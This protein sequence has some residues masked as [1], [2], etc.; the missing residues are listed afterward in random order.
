[1][2]ADR[3]TTRIMGIEFVFSTLEKDFLNQSSVF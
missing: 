1:M 3:G 2:W